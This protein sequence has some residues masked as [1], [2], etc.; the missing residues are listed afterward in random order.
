MTKTGISVGNMTTNLKS[1]L[2]FSKLLIKHILNTNIIKGII[3]FYFTMV[4]K[5]MEQQV[6][7]EKES[8]K[9]YSNIHLLHNIIQT[10]LL[11]LCNNRLLA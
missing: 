2:R 3:E 10:T 4:N 11:D 8:C 6:K 5:F 7:M 9:N 1:I